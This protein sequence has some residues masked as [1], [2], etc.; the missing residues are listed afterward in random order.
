MF[1]RQLHHSTTC[2]SLSSSHQFFFAILLNGIA[3]D[4]H[5][6]EQ[7]RVVVFNAIFYPVLFFAVVMATAGYSFFINYLKDP[8]TVLIVTGCVY[9][10]LTHCLKELVFEFVVTQS[11]EDLGLV[12]TWPY[13]YATVTIV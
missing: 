9:P 2:D 8:I 3:L 6:L 10:L 4:H 12:S 13:F 11:D 5:S 1:V 7:L